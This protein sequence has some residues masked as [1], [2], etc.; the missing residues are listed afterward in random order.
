MKIVLLS[1]GKGKRLW[2]LSTDNVPKQFVSL[3]NDAS[4]MLKK[5]YDSIVENYGGNNIYIATGNDY[6][7]EVLNQIKGFKNFILEPAYIGTFGAIINIAVYLKEI[8]KVS[9]D[10]IISI[11]PIDHDV[12][13]N[14][15]KILAGAKKII[16]NE[17]SDI[18]L[19]GIKPTFP[20]TQYGYIINSN[21]NVLSFKEKPNIELAAKLIIDN[22]L[23]NSGIVNFRLG[24]ILQI[25]KQ[26]LNYSSYDDFLNKYILLPHKSFDTEV[27]EKE[28]NLLV[29][30]CDAHW[31]DL[32]TWD[33]L[34]SKI[35]TSDDYNTNIINFENKR[36]V[37]E[38]IEN[39]IIVNTHDGI[40]LMKKN[41]NNNVFRQWGYYEVLN[42]FD[43]D[44]IHLKIKKLTIIDNRNISYQYH[45]HRAEEW[46]VL[47]GMGEVIIDG[48]CGKIKSGDIIKVNKKV[49]HSIRALKTLEIVEVQY[50]DEKIEEED[51]VRI[52]YNWNEIIKEHLIKR[53]N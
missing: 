16:E 11:V 47:K 25:A 29:I 33:M 12:D 50:G 41:I 22:A 40:K 13:K 37:N 48:K 20:S 30:G 5:T 2:P 46:F 6:R 42:V 18:C 53:S 26:Y 51:I 28:S 39:A 35:S 4:S 27:L 10:E 32:G 36:I 52:E 17:K 21:N 43:S 34:S 7:D 8:E 44:P 19:I 1:G 14:F 49:K 45:N 15:Y 3:F 31:N 24:K 38:G 9:N 23:W